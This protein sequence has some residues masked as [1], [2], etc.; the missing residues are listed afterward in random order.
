MLYTDSFDF[1]CY[2]EKLKFLFSL[3]PLIHFPCSC[4]HK[5]HYHQIL[6]Y[7]SRKNPRIYKHKNITVYTTCS[8]PLGGPS[9]H[10]SG[11]IKFVLLNTLKQESKFPN[12]ILVCFLHIYN[13]KGKKKEILLQ[14]Y[15]T[16]WING[17]LFN[18]VS[19]LYKLFWSIIMWNYICFV[20]QLGFWASDF[21]SWLF[22]GI[23]QLA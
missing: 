9:S 23:T 12:T 11:R 19:I 5:R 6:F 21:Q 2:K 3:C 20:L 17:K 1:F 18:I 22:I 8:S 4:S 7:H 13:T 14:C 16:I 15:L 10:L